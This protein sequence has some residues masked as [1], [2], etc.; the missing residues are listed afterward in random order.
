[1][2]E[3]MTPLEARQANHRAIHLVIQR[4]HQLTEA[5][6]KKPTF[7]DVVRQQQ[8]HPPLQTSVHNPALNPQPASNISPTNPTGIPSHLINEDTITSTPTAAQ[9]P[10]SDNNQPEEEGWTLV[11]RKKPQTFHRDSHSTKI[12]NM[13]RD[14]AWLLQQRRCFKCFLKGHQKQQCRRPIKCLLCNTE[15]HISKHCTTHINAGK[16][17]ASKFNSFQPPAAKMDTPRQTM[18]LPA[19]MKQGSSTFL[20]QQHIWLLKQGRCLKCCLRGHTKQHCTR[21]TKCFRCN[22]D[23][24][25][26]KQCKLSTINAK[27]SNRVTTPIN[28]DEEHQQ[29]AHQPNSGNHLH[30]SPHMEAN[31]QWETMDLMEPDDFED[32]RRESLRVFLPPGNPLRP[33]NSFLERSALVLAGPHQI[34]RYV[35]HRL[36]VKLAN[37]FNMQPRD[38]PISRVH[39][40]YGDFLVR[41]PNT[42][43]RDQAV[44]VCV[45]TLGPNMHLQL[46]EW[47]PG[48][49]GVY[50]PVTHKAR[51][52]LYGLPNHNWNIHS[53]DILVSGFGH[54]LRVES[55]HSTG[56]HQEIRIL[57]GC[58]HPINI[59]RTLDLSE[60]PHSSIVH[61][62][63]EGWMHDGTAFF[64]RDVSN[65]N[66]DEDPFAGPVTGRRRQRDPEQQ[67]VQ[68]RRANAPG[69]DNPTPGNLARNGD[70][71][72]QHRTQMEKSLEIIPFI[73]NG[74]NVNMAQIESSD[75]K[76]TGI[77]PFED[78][79]LCLMFRSLAL[80]QKTKRTARI[81]YLGQKVP[82]AHLFELTKEIA[83]PNI[84]LIQGTRLQDHGTDVPLGLISNQQGLL[85]AQN[86]TRPGPIIE[87]IL[88][89]Q[90]P[91]IASGDVIGR[92]SHS[93]ADEI[94]G[95]PPGFEGPP[96]YLAQCRR[97]PRLLQKHNGNYVSILQRAQQLKD[98]DH[99]QGILM[100]RQT[101]TRTPSQIQATYLSE[102]GPLTTYQA[103][104][105]LAAAGV[106]MKEELLANIKK[107]AEV[108]PVA[109]QEGAVRG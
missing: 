41:F 78:L 19:G 11:V 23:G 63:I 104:A 91:H 92:Q 34:N 44:A 97:S 50:D 108:V 20:Q 80:Y 38:F 109:V 31:Q 66:D 6:N 3:K 52:R 35:A 103:E 68:Q 48:M 77:F 61:V 16:P 14:Y 5:A 10:Q 13:K 25:I 55:F 82:A 59:P 67:Q 7:A 93:N 39:Q 40:N 72:P 17:P 22:K 46:V 79:L 49:G 43:L 106:D 60:E 51:L 58:F 96:A 89:K 87:E 85:T 36:A 53:L 42:S 83:G 90:Q 28:S 102:S 24:H 54:L 47:S 95:P 81:D 29:D 73:P 69:S 84:P 21:P 45:F 64:P 105:V 4:R 98:T 65:I 101:K 70:G 26:S 27:P 88:E 15:G 30:Q 33:I 2:V 8:P 62:V 32:G 18:P 57:V 100:A 75:Q 9:N 71:Q 76:A 74:E 56:N 94:Q 1:M 107:L 86:T 37:Y 12:S 99:C